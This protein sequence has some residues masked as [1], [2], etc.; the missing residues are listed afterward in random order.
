MLYFHG[1]LFSA[2]QG[3]SMKTYSYCSVYFSLCLILAISGRL[4]TQRKLNSR[5]KFL[6][7]STHAIFEIVVARSGSN[8]RHIIVQAKGFTITPLPLICF[9][10]YRQILNLDLVVLVTRVVRRQPSALTATK[11]KEQLSIRGCEK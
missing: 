1:V 5:K 3:L 6:M 10:T 2:F 9:Y 11:F 7:Y 8:P 4:R